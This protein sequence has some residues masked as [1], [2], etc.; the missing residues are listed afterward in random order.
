[1]KY[2]DYVK[3]YRPKGTVVKKINGIYY[4]YHATS[5]RV[6][7]KKYP[8][9]VVKGVAGKI[10][11]W[12]FHP[13]TSVRVEMGD[14][15]I[16]ECGFTNY[17]LMF[18]DLYCVQNSKRSRRD[19]RT[20]YRSMIVYLSNNSYLNDDTDTRILPIDRLVER[21]G[22]GVPN[23]VAAISRLMETDIGKLEPLKYI[24]RAVMGGRTFKTR[25]TEA[26]KR[27]IEELGVS[28]DEIR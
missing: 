11:R 28:E 8:V 26:Q 4:A 10:D 13:V 16:R 21:Y 20:V 15:V 23:Q 25:L 12:G 17:L 18:E 1:M 5:K 7:D 22:I 14:V 6:P 9:Q 3:K 24:C 2:P 19:N 27:I